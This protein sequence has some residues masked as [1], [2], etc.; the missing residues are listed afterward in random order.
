MNLAAC[1]NTLNGCNLHEAA[2]GWSGG[3]ILLLFVIVVVVIGLMKV[4]R[5]R[6]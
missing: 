1:P 2:S 6:G 5:R 3:G 4:G